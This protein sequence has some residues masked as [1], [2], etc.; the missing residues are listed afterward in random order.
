MELKVFHWKDLETPQNHF[1]LQ[2]YSLIENWI[3]S[4]FSETEIFF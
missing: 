1:D 4:N 2:C 3:E